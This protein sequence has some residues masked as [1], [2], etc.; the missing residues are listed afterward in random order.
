MMFWEPIANCDNVVRV[1]NDV[2]MQGGGQ[3]AH[4]FDIGMEI[5]TRGLKKDDIKSVTITLPGISTDD[6]IGEVGVRLTSVGMNG[7]K[8][9]DQSSKTFGP[10]SCPE[11][12]ECSIDCPPL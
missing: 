7:N 9:R 1:K 6:I 4:V 8:N 10:V 3:N 12:S 11:T 2:T 5:G